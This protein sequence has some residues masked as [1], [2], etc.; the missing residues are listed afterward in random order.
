MEELSL[1]SLNTKQGQ[2]RV[3]L[4]EHVASFIRTDVAEVIHVPRAER[5]ASF[6]IVSVWGGL[7][8][9][10]VRLQ[11]R[12]KLAFKLEPEQRQKVEQWLGPPTQ[13]N[14]RITLKRRYAFAAPI[15]VV[16]IL[17]SIP[18]PANQSARFEAVRFDPISLALGCGLLLLW[19]HARLRP[20][21]YL[22]LVDSIWFGLVAMNV[23]AD[24]LRQ[25]ASPLWLLWAV[26]LVFL[27]RSGIKQYKQFKGVG[28][29]KPGLPEQIV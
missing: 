22:F 29:G 1:I 4:Q 6:E 28:T 2:W 14:L 5:A 3:Q 16:F 15:A 21:P 17:T 13:E 7:V 25:A 8:V 9:L 24:V 18:L 20:K 11:G 26:L 19:A 12:K 23:I 27:I 10:T